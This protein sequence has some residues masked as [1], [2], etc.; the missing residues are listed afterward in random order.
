MEETLLFIL[1]GEQK[2]RWATFY[3]QLDARVGVP[4]VVISARLLLLLLF[5]RRLKLA[6]GSYHFVY[7]LALFQ[8]LQ[9]L[10]S[11][12]RRRQEL[13]RFDWIRLD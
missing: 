13:V 12:R 7:V 9:L 2:I 10:A 6:R 3:C 5:S 4:V 1:L 11:A 8:L